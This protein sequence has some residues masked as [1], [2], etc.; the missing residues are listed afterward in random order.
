[1][2]APGVL[3]ARVLSHP[4]RTSAA[5]RSRGV[6]QKSDDAAS[7]L[8]P[9]TAAAARA[10]VALLTD[11]GAHGDS[12]GEFATGGPQDE[13]GGEPIDALAYALLGARPTAGS[14]VDASTTRTGTKPVHWVHVFTP[15]LSVDTAMIA[16]MG[17]DAAQHLSPRQRS[18]HGCTAAARTHHVIQVDG[19]PCAG[20]ECGGPALSHIDDAITPMTAAAVL[21]QCFA[22]MPITA[23]WGLI[24]AATAEVAAIPPYELRST[25]THGGGG[26]DH[27]YSASNLVGREHEF[28]V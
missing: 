19:E 7:V 1:M 9:T 23:E 16:E 15:K 10:V 5:H 25:A 12:D 13:Q 4:L 18:E 21:L 20:D 2:L 11:R 17:A 22:Q 26:D 6:S 27:G 28:A 3:R 14:T 8:S 24:A